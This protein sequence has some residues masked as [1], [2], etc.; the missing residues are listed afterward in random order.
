MWRSIQVQIDH[1]NSLPAHALTVADVKAT[2]AVV[3]EEW[4][5]HLYIQTV[6]LSATLP[7][8]SRFARPVDYCPIARRLTV[9]SREMTREQA[10]REVLRELARQGLRLAT[11]SWNRLSDEHTQ[12]L[13]SVIAPLLQELAGPASGS[14]P[15]LP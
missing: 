6:R 4:R 11:R 15:H 2:L 10:R 1:L 14:A 3:P 7:Q 5:G 8:H 13:D 9:C 12:K